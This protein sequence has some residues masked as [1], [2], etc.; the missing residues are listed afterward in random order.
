MKSLP[1]LHDDDPDPLNSIH[2]LTSC[3]LKRLTS[4]RADHMR[5]P[6]GTEPLP[7]RALL[8]AA[9]LR[10]SA[11][12][13]LEAQDPNPPT[14]HPANPPTHRSCYMN[15]GLPYLLSSMWR[16]MDLRRV[17]TKK[18]ATPPR[19]SPR[20]TARPAA[21]PCAHPPRPL[22]DLPRPLWDPQVGN[23]P[24]F[25]EPVMLSNHR[26]GIAIQNFCD[27]LHASLS[28]EFSYALVRP[29]TPRPRPVG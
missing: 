3:P 8:S 7:S 12:P 10:H 16:A 29:R 14:R 6:S 25:V 18:A 4:W 5:S 26:G 11:P 9:W 1:P 27:Q 19:R 15:L 23:K 21:E 2:R 28:K 24:D 17:Y 20:S 13:A 22:W